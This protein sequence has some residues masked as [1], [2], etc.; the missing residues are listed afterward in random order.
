VLRV[1]NF[2]FL[3]EKV[4]KYE[5]YCKYSEELVVWIKRVMIQLESRTFP[6]TIKG[7]KVIM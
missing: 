7:M 4:V 6:T 2:H 1:V 5:E 3:Q